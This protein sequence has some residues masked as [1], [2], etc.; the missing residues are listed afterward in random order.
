MK[1]IAKNKGTRNQKNRYKSSVGRWK[2]RNRPWRASPHRGNMVALMSRCASAHRPS[3]SRTVVRLASF[4]AT[5]RVVY[6]VLESLFPYSCFFGV[7]QC[8]YIFRLA[9]LQCYF[10]K[11]FLFIPVQSQHRRITTRHARIGN[12]VTERCTDLCNKMTFDS[13]EAFVPIG[14]VVPVCSWIE[15]QSSS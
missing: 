5:L 14:N 12:S 1:R 4:E 11:Y 13:L 6:R 3:H 10:S 2:P 15:R 8:S 7:S 9:Y